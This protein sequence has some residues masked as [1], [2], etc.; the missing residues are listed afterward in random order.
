[1]IPPIC[2]RSAILAFNLPPDLKYTNSTFYLIRVPYC[3]ALY[4][5]SLHGFESLAS[6]A[7]GGTMGQTEV[8]RSLLSSALSF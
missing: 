4:V 7:V 3:T 6:L 1:M 2:N 8:A 5:I